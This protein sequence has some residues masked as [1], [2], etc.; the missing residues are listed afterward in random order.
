MDTL[1]G[2]GFG[3]VVVVPFVIYLWWITN[4]DRKRELPF[5]Y[6]RATEAMIEDNKGTGKLGPFSLVLFLFVCSPLGLG[7][8]LLA[9]WLFTQLL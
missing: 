5:P 4:R 2:L 1:I 8:L 3:L 9:Y 6:D 7:A